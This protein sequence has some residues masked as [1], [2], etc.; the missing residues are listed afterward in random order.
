MIFNRAGSGI[1]VEYDSFAYDAYLQACKLINHGDQENMQAAARHFD[2][3]LLLGENLALSHAQLAIAKIFCGASKEARQSAVAH[4]KRAQE[5]E[6]D[7][8][9]AYV[10]RALLAHYAND[11]ESMIGY[12][13]KALAANPI[14]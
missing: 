11:Y 6:P 9:E 7:L 1:V 4:L 3:A 10:G 14:C 2:R 8:A 13:R 5:L 12:L